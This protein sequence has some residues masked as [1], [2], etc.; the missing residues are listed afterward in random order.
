MGA[1]KK[2]KK[3]IQKKTV[4]KKGSPAAK[5]SKKA[6]PVR[7]LIIR[8]SG[9]K[10][11]AEDQEDSLPIPTNKLPTAKKKEFRDMLL[12]LRERLSSQITSLKGD[13]L[14]RFDAANSEEDGTD[15]FERQFALNLVSSEQDAL[16]EIDE[17][18]RRLEDGTY[19][20]CLQCRKLI[21]APRM[22]ALPFVKMC[23][24]CKAQNEKDGGK[25]GFRF[26]EAVSYNAET[27]ESEDA[28]DSSDS[29]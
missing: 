24:K 27:T 4:H 28:S 9:K 2:M 25:T 1:K 6:A 18:L 14:Q 10:I 7:K 5:H 8:K 23:V 21:E 17:A 26:G 12:R 19:G 11:P 16:F 22:K 3:K 20:V 13:S 15:A 29:N